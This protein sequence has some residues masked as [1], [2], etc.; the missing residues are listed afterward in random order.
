VVEER[1]LQQA[2]TADDPA[3]NFDCRAILSDLLEL[4][5]K[6]LFFIGG[7]LGSGTTWLQVLLDQHPEISCRG[8]GH[9]VTF[10]A[11]GLHQTIEWYNRYISTKNSIIYRELEGYPLFGT[12]E[13][14]AL[15]A[16]AM[17]LLMSKQRGGKPARAIGEKTPDNVRTFDGL[18]TAFPSA[19]F[20]HML[21]DPR[22]CA[23][24]GWFLAQ[25]TDPAELASIYPDQPSYFR[26]YIDLWV[27]ET[28]QGL[29]FGARHPERYVQIRYAELLAQSESALQPVLRFLGVDASLETARAC[30]SGADF[31]KLSGGRPRGT[32]DPSSHLRRGVV[33]DWVNHF[34]AETNEYFLKKAGPLMRRIG[35]DVGR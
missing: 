21:R 34:D 11:G 24:S 7:A 31:K 6:Q 28:I 27:P 8:E 13:F 30:I 32:A 22:D 18:R 15:H 1:P 12:I 17:L 29:E 19:K 33:G 20:I 16:T 9:F 10:L 2:A 3:K 26:N 35:V 14:N 25:R 23:V 5:S 4:L